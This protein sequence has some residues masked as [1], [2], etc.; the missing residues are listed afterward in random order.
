MS[1][2][3]LNLN[4]LEMG[5]CCP[6]T[7]ASN[8]SKANKTFYQPAPKSP[9]IVIEEQQH[10]Q[11]HALTPPMVVSPMTVSPLTPS[12]PAPPVIGFPP[13]A[14]QDGGTVIH[15]TIAPPHSASLVPQPTPSF[16]VRAPAPAPQRPPAKLQHSKSAPHLTPIAG[17]HEKQPSPSAPRLSPRRLPQHC[18]IHQHQ[19]NTTSS[20]SNIVSQWAHYYASAAAQPPPPPNSESRTP[21]S[22]YS[23]V[24]ST[25]STSTRLQGTDTRFQQRQLQQYHLLPPSGAR[26]AR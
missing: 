8:V 22:A 9:V 4:I 13:P 24:S 20:G 17:Q 25:P 14:I 18:F 12:P 5:N 15:L 6:A 11:P 19:T 1:F 3:K 2:N 16:V 26:S 7:K 23:S 21:A 10:Q